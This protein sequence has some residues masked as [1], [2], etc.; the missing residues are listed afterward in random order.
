MKQD[1]V[2][3]G[4]AMKRWKESLDDY[5]LPTWDELPDLNLYMDQVI[6]LLNKYLNIFNIAEKREL[7][8]PSMINNYVKLGII[9]PPYKKRYSRV[10]IAYL[11]TL[12]SLKQTLS[13]S[14]IQ[15]IMPIESTEEEVMLL[16]NSFVRN[17]QEAIKKVTNQVGGL[18]E[19][20]LSQKGGNQKSID[21]FAMQVA[22]SANIFK[23]L[24]EMLTTLSNKDAK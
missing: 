15:Q 22:A 1:L 6:A 13:M 12:C 18:W 24:T 10:H 9:P 17:Q 23:L 7:I 4:N 20:T 8:T 14:T 19:T 2:L 11:V 16:Y 21:N 3:M 5:Y